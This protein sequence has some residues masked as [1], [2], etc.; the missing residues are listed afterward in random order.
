MF[1][2]AQ[3]GFLGPF[4]WVFGKLL[5]FTYNILA[6]SDGI[7]NL[8]LCIIL[9]TVIVKLILFPLTFK[10]QKSTKINAVIQPEIQKIQKKYKDKKDQE[11]MVKQQQELQAVYDK[12]GTSMTSG[13]LPTLIQVP[14]IYALYRVIQNIP[15]Y[16]GK[17]K[18]MYIPIAQGVMNSQ[19]EGKVQQFLIDFVD[20]NSI[21]GA[22]YA[23]SKFKDL[24]EVGIDNIIDVLSN[25]GVSHLNTLMDTLNLSGDVAE[26]IDKID[27]IHSFVLGI[28]I[29]EAPGYKLS[30]ALLIPISSALFNFL[31]MKLTSGNQQQGDATTNTMMKSI[32]ITMP[33]MSIFICISLPAGIGIY[34]SV[35][36][37]ISLLTQ[38]ATNFYY[39][40][41]DMDAILEKQMEK[42]AKKKEKRGGKKSF[43]ER[44]MDTSA[45]AQEQLEK[46]Q[47]M[48][49][50]SAASLRNYVPSEKSQ[51]AVQQK[52]NK[53]YKEGS[54]GSKANI[55]MNY[56]NSNND[57]SN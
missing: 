40:H 25:F 31:S 39:D 29:S 47:A 19:G 49:K 9:F 17:I 36:A 6:G 46:Q 3:G 32:Q 41:V 23:I 33:L 8:G 53:K 57:K 44:M 50:N 42:A 14:I 16:V 28:N 37:L 30:W 48:K 20:E 13:C 45:E 56:N 18:D 15:A 7:A 11:S 1:L 38:L 35:S 22:S 54:L 24:A 10:Q 55:M 2:T 12:Y 21:S 27:Q 51:K 43:M 5:D 34:W 52:Q 26:N 4:A